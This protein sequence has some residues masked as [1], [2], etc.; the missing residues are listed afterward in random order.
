[1]LNLTETLIDNCIK[2]LKAAYCRTYGDR[3]AQ[4]AAL[5]GEVAHLTLGAIAQSDAPYHN[6]EH[7]ILVSLVGQEILRGKQL[8]EG[9]SHQD[10]LHLILALLCQRDRSAIA[11]AAPKRLETVFSLPSRRAQSIASATA[12]SPLVF[13]HSEDWQDKLSCRIVPPRSLQKFF[14]LN[15]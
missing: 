10:W 9:T 2:Q 14:F 8:Q 11:T 15:R 3:S 12:Y 5:I 1:M 7:T 4:F 13:Q 6:V